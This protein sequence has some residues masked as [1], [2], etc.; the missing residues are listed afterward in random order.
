MNRLLTIT[1][2]TLLAALAPA[3]P[4]PKGADKPTLYYPVKLGARWTYQSGSGERVLTVIRVEARGGTKVVH[5]GH[6]EAGGK[7]TPFHVMEVSARGLVQTHSGDQPLDRP[8]TRLLQPADAGARWGYH[9]NFSQRDEQV[10]TYTCGPVEAVVVPAGTFRAVRVESAY[11]F[12]GAA[13]SLAL[14]YAADVGEV[15]ME[16][17]GVTRVLTSFTPG[18]H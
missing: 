1:A 11:T 14:W 12:L 7:L 3:A 17:D 15:K 18:K 4:V 6:V 13:K 5:V 2:L 9:V 16:G 10:G 8:L